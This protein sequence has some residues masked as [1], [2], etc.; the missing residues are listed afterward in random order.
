MS[1]VFDQRFPSTNLLLNF[2]L[3]LPQSVISTAS[4]PVLILTSNIRTPTHTPD[5][6]SV[7][8]PMSCTSSA[9]ALNNATDEVLDVMEATQLRRFIIDACAST[10]TIPGITT[11]SVKMLPS[12]SSFPSSSIHKMDHVR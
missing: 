1:S 10:K 2:L 3:R 6:V 9:F 7:Q 4:D 8:T 5:P 12:F 11:A